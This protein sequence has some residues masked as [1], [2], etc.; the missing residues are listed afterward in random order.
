MYVYFYFF[1]IA[2]RL[3]LQNLPECYEMSGGQA[4]EFMANGGDPNAYPF[5]HS[6]THYRDCNFSFSGYSSYATS[7]IEEEEKN[8]GKYSRNLL[9]HCDMCFPTFFF[10]LNKKFMLKNYYNSNTY[11]FQNL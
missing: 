7:T 6:L 9:T 2:R 11:K 1:K 4:I 8:F 3:K 5:P 10:F